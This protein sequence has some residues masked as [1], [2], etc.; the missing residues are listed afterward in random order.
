MCRI[1][2]SIPSIMAMRQTDSEPPVAE[3]PEESPA[4]SPAEDPM[5]DPAESG[6]ENPANSAEDEEKTH[7]SGYA[8]ALRT[9]QEYVTML[10][11]LLDKARA[12]SEQELTAVRSR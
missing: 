5:E 7:V 12:R 10:Y 11:G 9:E 6:V 8:V 4:E 1:L 3:S 2:G